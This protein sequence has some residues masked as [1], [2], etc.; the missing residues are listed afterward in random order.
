M[1]KASVKVMLSYDYCHFEICLSSDSDMTLEQVNNLRKDAQRLADKSV[2][3]YK[4]AK[5]FA[6]KRLHL[7]NEKK[8]MEVEVKQYENTDFGGW[9]EKI[10][11]IDKALKDYEHW[12]QYDY[13]YEDED[14][15]EDGR[16]F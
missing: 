8:Q 1:P 3:Q 2:S 16:P 5:E 10:K 4:I 15:D 7:L 12:K 9:P 14:E 13:N 11:A 6:I